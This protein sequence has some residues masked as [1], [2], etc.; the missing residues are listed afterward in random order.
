MRNFIKLF[1]TIFFILLSNPANAEIKFTGH[2]WNNL[3]KI[4]NT[5]NP[6]NLPFEWWYVCGKREFLILQHAEKNL[7]T[8]Y[9]YI[10]GDIK[11]GESIIYLTEFSPIDENFSDTASKNK[12]LM[13]AERACSSRFKIQQPPEIFASRSAGGTISEIVTKDFQKFGLIRK[14]WVANFESRK[15]TKVFNPENNNYEKLVKFNPELKLPLK[16]IIAEDDVSKVWQIEVNCEQRTFRTLSL[17]DYND[18]N[19]NFEDKK[20]EHTKIPPYSTIED[21][22]EVSCKF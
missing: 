14:F 18:S 1:F 22:A 8:L 2:G 20:S 13:I 11:Q 19:M 6:E 10:D 12:F 9:K 17:V 4:Y 21:V 16:D 7:D 5:E 15:L 3:R